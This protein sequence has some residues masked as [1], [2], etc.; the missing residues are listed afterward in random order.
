MWIMDVRMPPQP[1]VPVV[2]TPDGQFSATLSTHTP[3]ADLYRRGPGRR[4]RDTSLFTDLDVDLIHAVTGESVRGVSA[5]H[6]SPFA[7]RI[8]TDRRT[9]ALPADV[10]VTR[11]YLLATGAAAEAH[12][13]ENP[14]S[15]A[16][17]ELA[18]AR[19]ASRVAGGVD[20]VC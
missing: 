16:T 3:A 14:F 18:L 11:R 6:L 15:G 8:L 2:A 12:G 20:I 4:K 7:S 1:A 5:E 13:A 19:L 10:E 17:L 9:G